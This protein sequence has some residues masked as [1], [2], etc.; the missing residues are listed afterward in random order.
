VPGKILGDGAADAPAGAGHQCVG[1]CWHPEALLML[2][3][4]SA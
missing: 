2:R 4:S 1:R 3:A